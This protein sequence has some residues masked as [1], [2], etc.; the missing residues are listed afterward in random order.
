MRSQEILVR[1]LSGYSGASLLLMKRGHLWF[2]RKIARNTNLNARL[3]IQCAK[4]KEWSLLPGKVI[5]CPRIYTGGYLDGLYYFDMEF[6]QGLDGVSFLRQANYQD[7]DRFCAT[8]SQNFSFLS[9]Q[10]MGEASTSSSQ[11]SSLYFEKILSVFE[12]EK[13]PFPLELQA[14]LFWSLRQLRGFRA[15]RPTICHGDFTLENMIV[16]SDGEIFVCDFLNTPFE[17]YWQDIAKLFQDIEGGWYL[18]NREPLP[19]YVVNYVS[20]S[21]L[22]EVAKFTPEYLAIHP[23]LLALNFAR[24]LPYVKNENDHEFVVSRIR[25]FLE[26]YPNEAKR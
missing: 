17:H 21:I 5:Q 11:L 8:I 6:I 20:E 13:Y 25:Y 4:Q 19:N 26:K 10:I 18:R 9:Q 15:D 7:I 12:Q 1:Q 3:Q 24:I 14:K 22:A 16:N 23:V 2:V